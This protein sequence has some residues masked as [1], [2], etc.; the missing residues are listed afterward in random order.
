VHFE[1]N[2]LSSCTWSLHKCPHNQ[3]QDTDTSDNTA[4]IQWAIHTR[5]TRY[6]ALL[7][8]THLT[9]CPAALSLTAGSERKVL[10]LR[11]CFIVSIY[12]T[13]PVWHPRQYHSITHSW[14]AELCR[15][16]RLQST[17]HYELQYPVPHNNKSRINWPN[18][19]HGSASVHQAQ[20]QYL[21]HTHFHCHLQT[22]SQQ[23][24]AEVD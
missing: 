13:S 12:H 22:S 21:G 19:S 20:S 24:R 2:C 14:A 16:E 1:P 15:L 7:L 4:L 17:S 11:E 18:Y 6:E 5:F 3:V 9:T 8:N 10:I 23:H